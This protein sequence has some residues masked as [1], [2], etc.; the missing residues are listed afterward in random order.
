MCVSFLKIFS[1]K[2]GV[3]R[4]PGGVGRGCLVIICVFGIPNRRVAGRDDSPSA[5]TLSKN[6][7][8]V[9]QGKKKH[10]PQPS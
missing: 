6:V 2:R 8:I 3:E 7:H 5:H 4:P 1:S 9:S 10:A